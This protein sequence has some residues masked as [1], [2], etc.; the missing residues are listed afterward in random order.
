MAEP[1]STSGGMRKGKS[2]SRVHA[3]ELQTL[4]PHSVHVLPGFCNRRANEDI[5][6]SS[7]FFI[8]SFLRFLHR[9]SR[10][11]VSQNGNQHQDFFIWRFIT[12]IVGL[13]N[14]EDRGLTEYADD[15]IAHLERLGIWQNRTERLRPYQL[16]MGVGSK[17]ESGAWKESN[18][19][20]V[21]TYSF[22]PQNQTVALPAKPA[23]GEVTE[24]NLRN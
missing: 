24:G 14:V 6:G 11:K 10:G 18:R 3:I 5:V 2:I 4:S 21:G 23:V 22:H 19:K 15:I 12:S 1:I 17:M 16:A 9:I 20:Y 7:H 8:R 13:N